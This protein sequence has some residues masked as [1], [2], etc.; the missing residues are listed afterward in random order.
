[1]LIDD[2]RDGSGVSSVR[3]RE[4]RRQRTLGCEAAGDGVLESDPALVAAFARER[5]LNVAERRLFGR[6]RVRA[7]ETGAR[8]GIAVAQRFEPALCRLAQVVERAH[9]TPPSVWC[10]AS[11]YLRP[12]EGSS[13][14]SNQVGG[15]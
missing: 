6:A 14:Q 7:S 11:A 10:L 13:W 9:G 4:Q 12:E 2:R 1:M 5:V 15:R 8:G 3:R